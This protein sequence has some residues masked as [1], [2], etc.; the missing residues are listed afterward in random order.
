MGDTRLPGLR[1]DSRG[2]GVSGIGGRAFC[3]QTASSLR[4]RQA[5]S[6]AIRVFACIKESLDFL[7]SLGTW[8]LTWQVR[9]WTWRRA[10]GDPRSRHAVGF[11]RP[12]PRLDFN[13]NTTRTPRSDPVLYL[14]RCP[15]KA[16]PNRQSAACECHLVAADWPV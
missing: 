6:L 4:S 11:T 10:N 2:R 14:W 7:T 13:S 3:R 16:S 1:C 8:L 15:V 12:Q 9:S 5:S